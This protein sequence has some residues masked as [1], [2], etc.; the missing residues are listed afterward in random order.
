MIQ[1]SPFS[2]PSQRLLHVLVITSLQVLYKKPSINLSTNKTSTTVGRKCIQ[3][4]GLFKSKKAANNRGSLTD[5]MK[6]H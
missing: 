3:E 4:N 1:D 2:F 6:T 5:I